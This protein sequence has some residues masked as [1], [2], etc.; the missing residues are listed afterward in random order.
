VLV[1][2]LSNSLKFSNKGSQIRINLKILE[3]LRIDELLD[4][5]LIVSD[6]SVEP[7]EESLEID[8][9]LRIEQESLI[10]DQIRNGKGTF[11][12]KFVLEV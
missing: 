10:E 11:K 5:L 7:N 12:I 6:V 2:L 8:P 9:S 1:N 4:N 3:K